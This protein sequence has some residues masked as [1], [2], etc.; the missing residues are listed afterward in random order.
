MPERWRVDRARIILACAEGMSNA[1]LEYM[2][3]GRAIVATRVGAND[4]LL[5]DG[6]DGLLIDPDDPNALT[7]AIQRLL[8]DPKLA[9]RLGASARQRASESFSR[10]AM[11]RRFEDLYEGLAAT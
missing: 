9:R 1:V 2:A 7:A 3:A 5:R 4:Q 8:N 6:D 11:C 10:N